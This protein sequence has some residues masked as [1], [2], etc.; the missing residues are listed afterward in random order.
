MLSFGEQFHQSVFPVVTIESE[1]EP[2][3][4][5]SG[6]ASEPDTNPLTHI[7]HIKDYEY[8]KYS[9]QPATKNEEVLGFQSFKLD[10]FPYS[11]INKVFRNIFILFV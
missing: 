2:Y 1:S 5:G 6:N 7:H 9:Q 4:G 11:A 10:R 3:Q 8:D